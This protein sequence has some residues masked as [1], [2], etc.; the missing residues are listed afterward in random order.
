MELI[1]AKKLLSPWQK[2]DHWFATNY[3]FNIYK[4]CSHGCIY[5]D[6]RS[7]C[8]QI[9]NF[10][11]VR[12]KENAIAILE[13]ELISKKKKGIVATGAMSDPYNPQEKKYELTRGALKLL[14][15]YGYGA[16]VTTKSDLVLRDID[17]Y[18]KIAEFSPAV[19]HFTI[20][21]AEDHLCKLVESNVTVSSKRFLAIKKLSEVGIFT[22]VRIWPI[23]PFINDSA[24]NIRQL[25]R[26]SAEAGARYVS[27]YFG[28]TLRQNQQTYFYQALDR[29]FPGLKTKYIQAF[30]NR[31]EC[32][33]PNKNRLNTIL[34]EEC[35]R[36]G[37]LFR[38]EDIVKAI[39]EKYE[40]NQISF[41]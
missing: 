21:T 30:G 35:N 41:F 38:M 9:E 39:K 19:V 37:L 40:V 25:I 33:S 1:S 31:Y 2:G 16:S 7:Q 10:D 18:K 13:M 23:L 15:K 36:Y 32:I 5:C 17:L 6:S 24:E 22:G 8:Y 11:E 34:V 26:M 4:G 27:P 29:K 14:A 20:T 28:V 12:G 3:N